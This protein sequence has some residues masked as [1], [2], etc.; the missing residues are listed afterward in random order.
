MYMNIP[1]RF[2]GDFPVSRATYL[3][4]GNNSYHYRGIYSNTEEFYKCCPAPAMRKTRPSIAE[5]KCLLGYMTIAFVVST[6]S[7]YDPVLRR[8]SPPCARCRQ[9]AVSVSPIQAYSRIHARAD[10]GIEGIL[11]DLFAALAI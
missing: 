1:E 6:N 10:D 5:L 7:S 8:T 9:Q 4:T 2:Y 3:R 11:K